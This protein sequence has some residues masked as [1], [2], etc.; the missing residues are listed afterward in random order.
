MIHTVIVFLIVLGFLIFVI[1]IISF[2]II[3]SISEESFNFI[4][5]LID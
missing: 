1:I 5:A 4:K 3:F 2:I